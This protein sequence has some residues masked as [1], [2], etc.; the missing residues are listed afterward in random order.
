MELVTSEDLRVIP[1][2]NACCPVEIQ[3]EPHVILNFLVVTLK[4]VRRNK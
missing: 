1:Q 3:C 4:D 2:R